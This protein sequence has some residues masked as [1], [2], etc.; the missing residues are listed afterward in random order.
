MKNFLTLVFCMLCS[1]PTYSQEP[2]RS[3]S[4]LNGLW[5]GT[6]KVSEQM[7]LQMAFEITPVDKGTYAAKMNVIEQKAF[8]IPMDECVVL[9]D[10]IH[11]S[12]AAAGITYKAYF[13][14]EADRLLGTYAQGGAEFPLDL[15]RVDQLPLEVERTQTPVRP[16]PYEETEVTFE[17]QDAGITLAGT[18]TKPSDSKNLAGVV[19][20]AGS[21]QNDRDETSMGHFLLLS[22]FLTR[23]GYAVLRYDKRG[24][25]ESG[26]DYGLATTYDFASD[27]FAAFEFLKADPATDPE[28][29]G[30]VGH[31]EGAL[32]APMLAAEHQ[33]NIAFIVMM[34]GIGIPGSDLLLIQSEKMARISGLPEE[35]IASITEKNRKL[36]QIAKSDVNDSILV[37]RSKEAVPDLD[38]ATVNMLKWSWFRTFLRLDPE[39]YLSR[40]SCPVLAITGEKDVQCPPEENLAAIESSLKKAGNKQVETKVM[41]GLNH[42]FQ[43][44]ESGSPYEYEQIPEI[45]SPDALEFMLDW[46]NDV[47]GEE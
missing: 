44:A 2:D 5:L 13:S 14:R 1:M 6:M 30:L 43:S 21:G 25:G 36:Y 18:L 11:I 10:S 9:G 8:D 41:P 16:F 22:D 17:N 15:A 46:L 4:P 24:V 28:A 38:E 3:E 20:I 42:L 12:F 23:N 7:S 32:I 26:G 37:L 19:L 33:E 47:N 35:E 34:G 45:M 31:S 27:A 40:V 29:V 39:A